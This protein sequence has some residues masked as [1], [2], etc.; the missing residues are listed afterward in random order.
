MAWRLAKSLSVLRDQV[1]AKY[2]GRSKVS[3]GTIGD[4][5]HSARKSD[6]NPRGGVVNAFDI[7]HDLRSGCD[8]HAIVQALLDSRDPRISYVI[9]NRR[10]C[11]G[12]GGPSPWKWRKYTGSNPHDKHAHVSVVDGT[13]AKNKLRD[14]T[15]P[16]AIDG[17]P[18]VIDNAAPKLPP[19]LRK[20]SH[21]PDVELAQK[22]LNAQGATPQL[23]VDQDFGAKTEKAVVA[24][25]RAHKLVADGV[26]GQQTWG[27]LKA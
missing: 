9:S 13:A 1:N 6:H 23:V 21:G 11:S 24:F 26:I 10:I 8:A 15:T 16:W 12:A 22:L 3:D 27:K 2:P 19:L 17:V 14:D 18:V 7:T 25:Q 5:A 20:G 4:A